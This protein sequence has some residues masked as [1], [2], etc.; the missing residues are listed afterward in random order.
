MPKE[1]RKPYN[2]PE[3]IYSQ[4]CRHKL[5]ELDENGMATCFKQRRME[6]GSNDTVKHIFLCASNFCKLHK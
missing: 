6:T 3:V 4:K 1:F 5:T 2:V